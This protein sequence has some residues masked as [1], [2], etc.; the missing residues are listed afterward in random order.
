ML[1]DTSDIGRKYQ[2]AERM[3]PPGTIISIREPFY[4][5]M[6]DGCYGVR[7]DNPKEVSV[8]LLGIP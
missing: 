7:V 6:A 3:F 5:L 8:S 1:P 4:K 2:A